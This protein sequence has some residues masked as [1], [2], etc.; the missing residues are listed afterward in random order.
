MKNCLKTWY[1]TGWNWLELPVSWSVSCELGTAR[2]SFRVAQPIPLRLWP[3]GVSPTSRNANSST[4]R[5]LARLLG[6]KWTKYSRFLAQ[7]IL[8]STGDDPPGKSGKSDGRLLKSVE[9]DAWGDRKHEEVFAA[10][11]RSISATS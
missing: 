7:F 5:S 1:Q 8:R 2:T 4:P 3:L 6:L 10:Q 9:P 11:I